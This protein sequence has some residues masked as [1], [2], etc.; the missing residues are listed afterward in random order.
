MFILNI[1]VLLFVVKDS[2]SLRETIFS[3][4]LNKDYTWLQT[5]F[6]FESSTV[7][8]ES[9]K[10]AN[11]IVPSSTHSSNDLV[12]KQ[13]PKIIDNIYAMH[14]NNVSPQQTSSTATNN[15]MQSQHQHNQSGND[16]TSNAVVYV[17]KAGPSSLV[18]AAT[19]TTSGTTTGTATAMT[20]DFSQLQSVLNQ[21]DNVLSRK[22]HHPAYAQLQTRLDSFKDWPAT[23]SQQPADLAKAGFYYFGIKDMVKCFFCNGG[24]KNWDHNDD[25]YQDHVR[26]FPGCQ[27]IRQLMGHE[28]IETVCE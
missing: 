3:N 14:K 26:W 7:N 11:I 27:F 25:P 15:S 18:A 1:F 22:A 20:S 13:I 10:I 4:P 9:K 28:Y 2:T 6:D 21:S 17:P 16:P 5:L 24:L 12:I 23:L 8:Y 19:G